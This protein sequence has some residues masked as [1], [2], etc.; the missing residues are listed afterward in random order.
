M[1]GDPLFGP[2]DAGEVDAVEEHGELAALE[3]RTQSV[4]TKLRQAE[5]SL[6]E[7]LVEKDE[8]PV[9]PGEY[10]R[11]VPLPA[12]EDEE[13]PGVQVFL[14]LVADDGGESVD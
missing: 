1:R 5:A 14:P 12:D 7:P 3:P 13:V 2:A 10:L 8:A 11:P 6:L 9:V 4:L